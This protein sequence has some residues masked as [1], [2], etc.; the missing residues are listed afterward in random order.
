VLAPL[1]HGQV[2]ERVTLRDA[3]IDG[4]DDRAEDEECWDR[5]RYRQPR[6]PGIQQ[7][8]HRHEEDLDDGDRDPQHIA[9]IR[10][11]GFNFAMLELR[12]SLSFCGALFNVALRGRRL[13]LGKAY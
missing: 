3:V 2:V 4:V 1:R 8:T 11:H 12:M 7:E 9:E 6:R 13:S 5:Q 10:D